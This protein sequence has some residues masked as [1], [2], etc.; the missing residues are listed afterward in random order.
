MNNHDLLY[1]IYFPGSKVLHKIYLSHFQQLN[2]SFLLS[3][4][5]LSLFTLAAFLDFQMQMTASWD[6]ARRKL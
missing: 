6:F 4:S 1:E 5:T 3:F 2:I